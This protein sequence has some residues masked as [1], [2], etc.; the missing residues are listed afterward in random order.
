MSEQRGG[1]VIGMNDQ[2]ASTRNGSRF[3][4]LKHGLTAK[5][6]VLPGEDPAELQ[7][8]IDAYKAKYQTR[9]EVEGDLMEMAAIACWQFKRANR[10]EAHRVTRDIVMRTEAEK[11]R[12][13]K[14]VAG[15]GRRLLF[16]RRGP[17]QLFPSRDYENKQPRTSDSG[18]PVDPDQPV[19]IVR[20]L[21]STPEGCG[22]LLDRW[23]ELR[24][25]IENESEDGSGWLSCQ[26][27][28]AIRLLGKQP[29]DAICD[30][31]V[32]MVFLASHAICPNF[33]TAFHELRCEIHYDQVEMHEGDLG[34]DEWEAITPADTA[35]GRKA[36]LEIVDKSID[37]LLRLQAER[38]EVAAFLEEVQCNIPSDE[39]SKTMAQIQRHREKANRLVVRN[40]EMIER[41]RRYEAEG[42]GKARR[43]REKLKEQ[44]RRGQMTD[45]RFVIDER[46]TIHDAQGYDGDL[47]AGLARWEATH[48]KQPFEYTDAQREED[49]RRR[50]AIADYERWVAG[51]RG[52]AAGDRRADGVHGVVADGGMKPRDEAFSG[53]GTAVV[54]PNGSVPLSLMGNEPA[55][56]IQN[57]IEGGGGSSVE[58]EVGGGEETVGQ[59]DGGDPSGAREPAPN[60]R[61]RGR[62]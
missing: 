38:G 28:T 8:K 59:G 49:D 53:H 42:W 4:A 57:E 20:E 62:R 9:D 48:G 35:A 24:K 7:A 19:V 16:D 43:E 2:R 29:L 6:P 52:N 18:E 37:R 45:L 32:A 34:R 26:K 22:W 60:C 30:P 58:L 12:A 31:E 51:E 21:E 54:E 40:I 47:D 10:I 27:F 13:G 50:R 44:A 23:F 15:L 36:L 1:V 56:K 39:E 61:A 5:T 55:T 14:D 3:N 17:W 25:P 11:V 33:A 41:K 46:G